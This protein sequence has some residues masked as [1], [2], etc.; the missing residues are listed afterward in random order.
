MWGTRV[1][2]SDDTVPSGST[3][4][5]ALQTADEYGN[6]I[7]LTGLDVR[8]AHS[9]GSSVGNIAG[10]RMKAA[11]STTAVFT[12]DK[13]GSATTITATIGGAGVMAPPPTV[14]VIAR[15]ADEHGALGGPK[16]DRGGR[17]GGP[18]RSSRIPQGRQ[19]QSGARSAR[20][21]FDCGGRR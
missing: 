12:G 7:P 18:N 19:E 11:G 8:F 1:T 14:V 5:L 2:V 21:V 20:D 10:T 17:H 3:I 16:P 6:P 13:A 15:F 9:G 4:T